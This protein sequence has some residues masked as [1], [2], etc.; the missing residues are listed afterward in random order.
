VPRH[1]RR[2]G[3]EIEPA[4]AFQHAQHRERHRHQGWLGILGKGQLLD[5]PCEHQF[6]EAFA[7][8]VV[9]FLEHLARGRE[10]RGEIASHAGELAALSG[11]DE[12]INGHQDAVRSRTRSC[13]MGE[14]PPGCQLRPWDGGVAD[15]PP[16]WE[17]L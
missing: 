15:M 16:E 14:T 4:L 5:R 6:G 17:K 1:Q 11:E 10:G 3:G 7:E 8:R 12:G 13:E 2:L 9:D